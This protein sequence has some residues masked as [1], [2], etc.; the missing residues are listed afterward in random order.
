[1]GDEIYEI[2]SMED[3]SSHYYTNTGGYTSVPNPGWSNGQVTTTNTV[4]ISVIPDELKV[5]QICGVGDVVVFCESCKEIL[6]LAR[7]VWAK[8]MMEEI[9]DALS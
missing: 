2:R 8:A 1:M 5:C 7:K 6:Q 4:T 9:E 3:I